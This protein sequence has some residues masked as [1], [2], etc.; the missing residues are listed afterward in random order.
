MY[1][2]GS[3]YELEFDF[4]VE[5]IGQPIIAILGETEKQARTAAKCVK[6]TYKPLK[7]ILTIQVTCIAKSFLRFH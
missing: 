6:V 5:G 3:T 4:K 7:P 2:Y 1:T